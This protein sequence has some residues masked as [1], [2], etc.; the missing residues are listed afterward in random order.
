MSVLLYA[1]PAN[2][3]GK[4]LQRIIETLVPNEQLEI[5]RSIEGLSERLRRP[6]YSRLTGVFLVASDKELSNLL[7]IRNMLHDL[8][9]I[10]VL[11]DSEK[12]TVTKGF[13]LYPRFISYADSDFSDVAA[14]LS[15]MLGISCSIGINN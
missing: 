9:F 14:V 12:N 11:P 7:S 1:S 10:L 5:C 2:A 6:F 8:R 4:R 3:A 13:A 15:K